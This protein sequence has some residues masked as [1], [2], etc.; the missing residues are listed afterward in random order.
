MRQVW[1]TGAE[2]SLDLAQDALLIFG[3]RHEP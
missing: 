3:E 2:L 1:V